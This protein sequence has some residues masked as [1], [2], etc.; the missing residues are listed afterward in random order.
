MEFPRYNSDGSEELS[1]Q[2][3]WRDIQPQEILGAE[4]FNPEAII[5]PTGNK[6]VLE[7]TAIEFREMFSALYNG[8]EITYP[9]RYLQIMVNF[10]KGLHCSPELED[11]S[12]CLNF[13]PSASFV[14]F[15]PQNPYNEPNLVPDG[16]LVPPFHLNSDFLYPEI[17]G[18]LA[19]DVMV[20]LD[21]IPI[22]GG[23]DDLIGL[24]FPTIKLRVKG[25][26]QIELD[27]I[28]IQLGGLVVAKVGSPPNILDLIDGIIETGV[29]IID[30]SAEAASIPIE[31]DMIV[32]D[33]IP[34]DSV[35]FVDVYLTFVP[36][37]AADVEFY[38]FGG[39]I[40]Q[41][42]L[43]GLEI[44]GEISMEDIRFN[45]MTCAL[46]KRVGGVWLPVE[47]WEDFE[48]CLPPS[49]GG[50]AGGAGV[51]KVRTLQLTV[52]A[53]TTFNSTSYVNLPVSF[54]HTPEYTKML[55]IADNLTLVNSGAGQ[56]DARITVG[57]NAGIQSTRARNIGTNGRSLQTSDHWIGLTAGA[58]VNIAI[59]GRVSSGTGTLNE[60]AEINITI[61][62]F[63]NPED[64]Y[65]EDVRILDWELQKKI[66]GV[67]LTVSESLADALI[68]I[69]N[70]AVTALNNA[71]SAITVNNT[72]INQINA[73][74]NLNTVQN[75]RILELEL[76]M[77]DVQLS[78]GQIN[79]TLGTVDSRLDSLES[80]QIGAQ[81]FFSDNWDLRDSPNGWASPSAVWLPDV[82]YGSNAPFV[83]SL[84]SWTIYDGAPTHLKLTCINE[85]G[86]DA[87]FDV[88][89]VN[90]TDAQSIRVAGNTTMNV[91]VR[92]PNNVFGSQMPMFSVTNNI[93]TAALHIAEIKLCGRG[94]LASP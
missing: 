12:G 83:L 89:W 4:C 20:Q 52:P 87:Y 48:E 70:L 18:F 29:K 56:T 24:N 85:S 36:K 32:E 37:I 69:Q 72:Q 78:I 73:I 39:G 34:I 84:P 40:R 86:G 58:A 46:E 15:S 16:Y 59:Q 74:Q 60:N 79:L 63:D 77:D 22:F 76:D 75:N 31:S 90:T 49:G 23:W 3:I 38:G 14:S 28:S 1:F 82:G 55:V 42:G 67:W 26:G 88:T 43:C 61:L 64:L 68:D 80:F 2:N 5:V 94:Q 41:I 21:A 53:A 7:L 6:M 62:E 10:L 57:G 9:D 50:G 30:V 17:F 33:E 93:N 11:E 47:G 91:W 54:S 71:N 35:D 13:L 8:A 45:A 66:G 44:E 65:V 25:Q 19:T 51:L 27:L 81:E 92:I